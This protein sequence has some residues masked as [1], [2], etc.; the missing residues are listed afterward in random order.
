MSL[1]ESLYGE[2]PERTQT[3]TRP[4]FPQADNEDRLAQALD[5]L[6]LIQEVKRDERRPVIVYR[7]TLLGDAEDLYPV[8]AERF[9]ALGYTP[10]L[11]REGQLDIVAALEGLMVAR[12]FSTPGWVHAL[13][14]IVTILTTT[15]SGAG[16]QGYDFDALLRELTR[17]H[18]WGY[19]GTM[20]R[21][22]APFALTLL[23]ILGVHEMGHYVAARRH[24]IDVT[25]PYFIPLP[26]ISI[27][28]TLGAVIFIKSALTNRK[29]LFDVG[30]SGPL[31]GFVVAL[32]AFIVGLKMQPYSSPNMA[33]YGVFRGFVGLGMPPLLHWL[34]ELLR[35]DVNLGLFVTRQPIAL[36]AWFG[37]LLTVLNLLPIG[38]LD[39][40]HVVYTLFGRFAWTI[41]LIALVGLIILGLTVFPSFLF[42]AML[43][44]L[45]GVR[46]PPPGNDI[47]PLNL[48]RRLLGYA[49]IVLFFLILTTTPFLARG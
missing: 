45:T 15:L 43:A 36:A 38:Q 9:K 11:R 17:Y 40:G 4:A 30:I 48:P 26:F 23:L 20:I 35:P 28:G 42:Y 24:G 3:Q 22:G 37:M 6:M 46:H 19:I 41:A 13:L 39:G 10:M 21:A 5:G 49:T 2:L 29:A 31:A 16:F 7:G 25:L 12:R 33:F 32:V 27:L 8:I 44:A 47:T 14:L 1:S 18:N 34:G